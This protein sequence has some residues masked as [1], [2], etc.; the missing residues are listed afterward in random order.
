MNIKAARVN[1]ADN[2]LLVAAAPASRPAGPKRRRSLMGKVLTARVLAVGG[3]SKEQKERGAIKLA[4]GDQIA[5]RQWERRQVTVEL[6]GEKASLIQINDV[7]FSFVP[8]VTSLRAPK[9]RRRAA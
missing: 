7:Q 6:Q 4:V 2:Y 5:Y 3:V 1:L 8:E 9:K